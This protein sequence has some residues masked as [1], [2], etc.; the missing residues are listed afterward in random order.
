MNKTVSLE[1]VKKLVN[2]GIVLKTE[3]YWCNGIYV[4]DFGWMLAG[5][6]LEPSKKENAL[7][8]KPLE[9]IPTKD[10]WGLHLGNPKNDDRYGEPTEPIKWFPAPD[11]A[12]LLEALPIGFGI[13]KNEQGYMC[14]GTKKMLPIAID[15]RDM[16]IGHDEPV[17]ALAQLLL[18]LKSQT[19]K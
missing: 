9:I 17:E 15:L 4:D 16:C 2:S 8:F 19:N 3:K 10:I 13:Y 14:C 18:W 7:G 1:T 12:E 5:C 11:I 6:K